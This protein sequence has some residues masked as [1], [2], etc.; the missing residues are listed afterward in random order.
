MSDLLLYRQQLIKTDLRTAWE[1]FSSP[2]NLQKIT[3]PDLG[4]NILSDL[5]GRSMHEG[6]I[7]DYTVK[8]LFGI[9]VRWRTE[10]KQVNE[11]SSF[12]DVQKRGPYSK[13]E[14][15][16]VFEEVENGV[17]VKDYVKFRLP[18]GVLGRMAHS[19]FVK[20]RLAHIFDYRERILEA[21]FNKSN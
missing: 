8:P 2:K 18:F 5:K 14:H 11:L 13:W 1:F 21:V 4:F 20:A 9:P 3:P 7:I 17:L 12:K 16:H 10:I 6:Q 19:V 15:T